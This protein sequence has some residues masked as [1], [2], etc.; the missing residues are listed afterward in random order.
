MESLAKRFIN[1]FN[2]IDDS[3][4]R[5]FNIKRSMTF[6]EM[7]RR[8]STSSSTIRKYEEDLIS[9]SR[10][11]NAIVHQSN[12]NMIIA[13]PHEEIVKKIEKICDLLTTPP[14]A[15]TTVQ[16]KQNVLTVEGSFFIKDV[17][18]LMYYSGYSNLP[19]YDGNT[20]L[21]VANGQR[22]VDG[23]GKIIKNKVDVNKYIS[24]TTIGELVS[25]EQED[26]YYIVCPKSLTI[27]DALNKFYT[28]RKLLLI[29]ITENGTHEEKPLA[30]LTASNI[31]DMN[32]ILDDF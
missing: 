2:K 1:S 13:E 11:R 31:I 19:V 10:L 21:G 32:N 28:N 3:L 29:I 9:Y 27:E 22:L 26:I 5:Q 4:R 17:I 14:L 6:T 15:Y 30:L 16:G 18:E 23:I 25:K 8:T 24:T 12:D 20:L 7:V